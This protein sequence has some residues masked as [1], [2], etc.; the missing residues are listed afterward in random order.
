MI[1]K[2]L[3]VVLFVSTVGVANSFAQSTCTP[4]ISCVPADSTFGIC[5]DSA[6]GLPAGQ[7]GTPYNV[8]MS[9][10]I[11][12]TTVAFGQTVTLSH[13]ALTE[14]LVD[15]ATNGTPA[16]VSLTNIGLDYLGS[17]ANSPQGGAS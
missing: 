11:P 13:L 14:V 9:I 1:K 10:K 17:G 8:T 16:Y 6:A 5:P 2:L 12:G 3:S 7:I 4:N 15:T